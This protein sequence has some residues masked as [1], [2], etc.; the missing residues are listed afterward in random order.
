MTDIQVP[1]DSFD[2]NRV[3]FIVYEGTI[4]RFERTIKRLLILVAVT[5]LLL[6]VSNALWLY[7]WNQYEY[8]DATIAV[9]IGGGG[10]DTSK[11]YVKIGG[12]WKEATP[13]KKVNGSWVLQ[14]D[15]TH[16]FDSTKKY[17]KGN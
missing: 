11:I 2:D 8:T 13:Y 12:T 4:A 16:V 10:G 14:T 5:I 17:V 6:F 3:P 15:V 1:R 9:T 7:E